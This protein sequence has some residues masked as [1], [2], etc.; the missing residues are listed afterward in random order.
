VPLW[1]KTPPDPI[2]RAKPAT[3]RWRKT[4]FLR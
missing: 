1:A 2:R 4:A 3:A